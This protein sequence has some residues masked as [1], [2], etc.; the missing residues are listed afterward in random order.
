MNEINIAFMVYISFM[1][2]STLACFTYGSFI[3]KKTG[4]F[5]QFSLFTGILYF[6]LGVLAI[7]GW[8]FFSWG[9]NEFLFFNGLFLG[10]GMLV[11]GEAII[12]IALFI[13][14]KTLI[15][16]YNEQYHIS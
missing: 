8:S 1:V 13:K 12:F 3:I 11:L 7:L 2:L 5:T 16:S 14:K 9:I 4:L 6:S 10:V 15:R